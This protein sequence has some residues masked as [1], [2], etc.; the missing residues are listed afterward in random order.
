MSLISFADLRHHFLA[1]RA[2]STRQ[3]FSA[4]CLGGFHVECFGMLGT[5]EI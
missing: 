3:R 5:G 4:E 1:A 2:A